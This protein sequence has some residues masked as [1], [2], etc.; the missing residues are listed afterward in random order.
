M[1][2]TRTLSGLVSQEGKDQWGTKARRKNQA[3]ITSEDA[4]RTGLNDRR[5]E[6][7]T[8]IEKR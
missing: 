8:S 5:K 4:E 7:L 2:T 6:D 3:G 1:K